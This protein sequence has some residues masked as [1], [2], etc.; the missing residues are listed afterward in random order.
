MFKKI[1]NPAACEMR[2]VIR[3]LN[4][5][6]MKLADIHCQLCE[7]YAEHAISD[8]MARIWVKV[9]VKLSLY[10][11]PRPLGLQEVE[12]PTFSNIRFIDGGK[13]VSPMRRPL[14]TPRAIVRLEG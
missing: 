4:A 1:E 11:P 6:N 12:A 7:V 3:I 2:S 8:S 9:K 13:V 10:R 14:F 5:R